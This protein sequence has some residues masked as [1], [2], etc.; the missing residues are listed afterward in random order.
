MAIA[1]ISRPLLAQLHSVR[2]FAHEFH[3]SA[4]L[5]P[6]QDRGTSRRLYNRPPAWPRPPRESRRCT[7][8]HRRALVT[9][10]ETTRRA[11]SACEEARRPC[12]ARRGANRRNRRAIHPYSSCVSQRQV[13]CFARI[14][15]AVVILV[16]IQ[17]I[18]VSGIC[19]EHCHVSNSP[20]AR[21]TRRI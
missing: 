16:A 17:Q 3:T 4:P 18:M 6:T 2:S 11:S 21:T 9:P 10:P 5:A 8:I 19:S 15:F 12:G 13:D 20:T 14:D 7:G 1:T